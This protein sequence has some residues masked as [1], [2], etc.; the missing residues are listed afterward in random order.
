[1]AD[2]KANF[3]RI[4]DGAVAYLADI[5]FP[6]EVAA[7][8]LARSD[9]TTYALRNPAFTVARGEPNGMEDLLP[10]ANLDLMDAQHQSAEKSADNYAQIWILHC[11]IGIAV[12]GA[13]RDEAETR[14]QDAQCAVISAWLGDGSKMGMDRSQTGLSSSSLTGGG[15]LTT[16]RGD[17]FLSVTQL[18]LDITVR[19]QLL[20]N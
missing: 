13:T 12:L 1:M 15:W 7:L 16:E 14:A 18:L 3:M 17:G 19:V 5:D 20:R 4:W 2:L 8:A 11:K 10:F 6:T 9:S